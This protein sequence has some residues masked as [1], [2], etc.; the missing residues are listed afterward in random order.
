MA[1][2]RV[3]IRGAEIDVPSA[4]GGRPII[5][6]YASRAVRAATREKAA[7]WAQALVASNWASEQHQR[8][9]RKGPPVLRVERV[10]RIGLLRYLTHPNHGFTFYTDE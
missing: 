1:V 7:E 8:S 10:E 9:N 2:Y 5:G 4:D 3:L 6:F